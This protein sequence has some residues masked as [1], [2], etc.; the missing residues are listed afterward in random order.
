MYRLPHDTPEEHIGVPSL[1][2]AGIFLG[3]AFYLLPALFKLNAEGETQR[4]SGTIYAWV[5]SF[6]LP[7]GRTSKESTGNLDYAVAQARD[8]RARTGKP[9]RI[10]LDFT[11]VSCTNCNLNENNVFAKADF[12]KLLQSFIIVQLYTDKVPNEFY[13]PEL[14]SKFGN[15]T[16]RQEADA[17]VNET[18][19]SKAFND[20]R[21]PLY[22]ILEPRTDGKID[23]LGTYD[24]GRIINEAGFAEF[25]RNPK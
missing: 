5:D 7:D 18:F 24:E 6:L 21:L 15:G 10:F 20:L 22:A 13:A 19:E 14:Q 4:P 1:V 3:L 23:V 16:A 25:L 2:F 11:G 17:K 9:K 12:R 8:I